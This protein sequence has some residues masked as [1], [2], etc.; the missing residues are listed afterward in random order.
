MVDIGAGIEQ[1]VD[2]LAVLFLNSSN[3]GRRIETVVRERFIDA[4]F[5]RRVTYEN[6]ADE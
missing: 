6:I 3:H 4:R 1:H 2:D 5:E